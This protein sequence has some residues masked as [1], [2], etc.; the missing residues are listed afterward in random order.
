MPGSFLLRSPIHRINAMRKALASHKPIATAIVS[1]TI[2]SFVFGTLQVQNVTITSIFSRQTQTETIVFLLIYG[3]LYQGAS[4]LSSLGYFFSYF[5]TKMELKNIPMLWRLPIFEQRMLN[6]ICW[7]SLSFL[8]T[9]SL[10]MGHLN[11]FIASRVKIRCSIIFTFAVYF[12]NDISHNVSRHPFSSPKQP[13]HVMCFPFEN[14][15]SVE[16]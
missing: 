11:Y 4:V 16:H 15:R 12:S 9:N 1:A 8:Y 2:S 7:E 6:S 10:S 13:V 3:A 5:Y 14:Q